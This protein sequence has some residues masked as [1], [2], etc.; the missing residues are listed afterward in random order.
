MDR[1]EL[2]KRI[3]KM[4]GASPAG[5]EKMMDPANTDE[6]F[7]MFPTGLARDLI[8]RNEYLEAEINRIYLDLIGLAGMEALPER[9]PRS[10]WWPTRWLGGD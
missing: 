3:E 1:V 5:F 8:L 4:K 10:S 9:K 7:V 6:T 2:Q